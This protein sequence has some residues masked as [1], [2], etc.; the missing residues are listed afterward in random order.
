MRNWTSIFLAVVF[1]LGSFISGTRSYA[2]SATLV[3]L[4]PLPDQISPG[5]A[6]ADEGSRTLADLAANFSNPEEAAQFLADWDWQGNTFRFFE[7]ADLTDSGTLESSVEV[8]IT[9]FADP[10]GAA[11]ALSYFLQDRAALLGQTEA[12][13]ERRIGDESR[14]LSGKFEGSN[15]ST[16]Y[17]RSGG[18]VVRVTVRSAHGSLPAT[19]ERIA[20]AILARATGHPRS[21]EAQQSAH[22][23]LPDTLPLAHA[24]CFDL[25][26]EGTLDFPAVVQ[27]FPDSAEAAARLEAW[28]W[29][30]GAYRQFGCGGPPDGD[31]GWLDI[32]VHRFGDAAS[33]NAAVSYFANARAGGTGLEEALPPS[34]GDQAVALTGPAE[35]G[36][37]YTLYVRA[38]PLLFR[39]TGVAPAGVPASD[40]EQIMLGLVAG[41][42]GAGPEVGRPADASSPPTATAIPT[43]TAFPIFTLAPTVTPWPVPTATAAPTPPLPPT[44]AQS[45]TDCELIELY[46]GYPGY[47]GFVAGLAGPGEVACLEQL[48]RDFPW[49]DRDREDQENAAAA[50]RLGLAGGPKDWVW[51]NWLAI[52]AERGLP[53]TCYICA[54]EQFAAGASFQA[55]PVNPNDVRLLVGSFGSSELLYRL[56]GRYS[57]EM[58]QMD[59]YVTNDY[60]LRAVAWIANAPRHINAQ[61]LQSTYEVIGAAI[62]A[63]QVTW[64]QVMGIALDQGGYAPTPSHAAIKDQVFLLTTALEAQ[65]L[66]INPLSARSLWARFNAF[67]TEWI[68]ER[69]TGS[70]QGLGEYIREH[71]PNFRSSFP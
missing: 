37:E 26:D 12:Q 57:I 5:L 68:S 14:A 49:F 29:E 61:E 41:S 66:G 67:V 70:M 10:A 71:G 25:V 60:Q 6:I 30:D 2:Q 23:Y 55:A 43:P 16:L 18:L 42:V 34:I 24:A 54:R 39:V 33:A 11:A 56:A 19:P 40:V 38:G 7:S 22:A 46:P 65:A 17:V 8:S 63:G 32:S 58:W 64:W 21:V 47:R 31:A 45:S 52:E 1:L 51:E 28:G 36:T 48:Q 69:G 59:Y 4:L 3:D 9:R 13:P 35:N 15:E 62:A 20:E 27:R 50:V 44:T 53:L